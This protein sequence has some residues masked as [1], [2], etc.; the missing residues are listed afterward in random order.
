MSMEPSE[1]QEDQESERLSNSWRD[2][3]EQVQSLFASIADAFRVAWSEERKP[4]QE[5]E[6][7][8][9]LEDDLR[10]SADRLERVFKRVAAETE[11]ERSAAFKTTREASGRS[12]GEAKIVA[13]RGLRTLNQQLDELA[14]TLERERASRDEEPPIN[15]EDDPQADH[16]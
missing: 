10:A 7:A 16:P 15:P 8:K 14:K 1:H 11:E 6:S 4:E 9:R 2:V 12:L 13:A 5:G 3:G